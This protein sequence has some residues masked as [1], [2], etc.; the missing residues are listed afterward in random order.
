[1]AGE[2][3]CAAGLRAALVMCCRRAERFF[4]CLSRDCA[5]YTRELCQGY[6]YS[7]CVISLVPH[8]HIGI[9]I[10]GALIAAIY[11]KALSVD[12][13]A[14]K[15]GVG[16]LNNLMSVDVSVSAAVI[17]CGCPGVCF[18]GAESQD[19]SSLLRIFGCL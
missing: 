7:R 3:R 1:V 2:C 11:N 17:Y 18:F 5:R 14:S 9:R 15:E 4:L 16:K 8:R 6:A 19:R 12:L 10:K 13:T